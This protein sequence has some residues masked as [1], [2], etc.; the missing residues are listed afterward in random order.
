M[1]LGNIGQ[2]TSPFWGKIIVACAV[3]GGVLTGYSHIENF[4]KLEIIGIILLT[5]GTAGPVFISKPPSQ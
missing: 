3:A 2:P 4:P 1:K 5:V